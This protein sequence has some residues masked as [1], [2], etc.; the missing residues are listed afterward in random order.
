[1]FL[2]HVTQVEQN[3]IYPLQQFNNK[4]SLTKTADKYSLV[5]NVCPHQGSLILTEPDKEFTCRYHGWSWD[6]EGK[7][8]GSGTTPVCNNT[9]LSHAPVYIE[10]NL[11]FTEEVDL[12]ILG[13]DLS[14]MTLVTKR[15][16]VVNS[17]WRNIVDVFLD[18]DHIPVVHKNVYD[19]IGITSTDV[20]WDYYQWGSI[21]RVNKTAE[22]SQEFKFT[23]KGLPEED[24]AAWWV[25][26]YPGTMIEWQPGALFVTQCIERDTQTDVLVHKYRDTRY[27][28]MNW[29]LNNEIWE[30][31]WKQDK[32]Q[33]EAI[34]I[35][36][37]KVA[38]LEEQKQHFRK[39]MKSA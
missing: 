39:W 9:K 26:V 15:I 13:V 19:S 11:L 24:L 2:G 8:T 5:N 37:D 10:N 35:A 4:K 21:Q 30:T 32:T 18:V 36:T 23:L 31:A 1:M 7:P 38:H 33:S 3:I 29:Q 17:D 25:T 22:Y 6:A 16:D 28:D 12:S 34:V 14:Y 27:S 20:T